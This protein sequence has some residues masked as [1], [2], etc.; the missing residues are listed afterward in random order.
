MRYGSASGVGD[1]VVIHQNSVGVPGADEDADG[2][3]SSLAIGDITADGR[4]ELV[5]GVNGEDLGS[6]KNAGDVAVFRGSASGVSMSGVVR[7]SQGTTGVPG[8]PETDDLFGG[9]VR[10]ADYNHNGKADLAVTA[11][12]E[13]GRNGALWTLLGTASGLTGSGSKVFGSDDYGLA[14]GSRL[15]ES[16]LD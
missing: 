9:Q 4:A 1:P 8:G 2:F 13:N 16:L 12:F 10:L 14:N 11:P 5:V 3:G 15:G 6:T 7:I